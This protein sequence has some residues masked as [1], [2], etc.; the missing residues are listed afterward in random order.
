MKLDKENIK[1][2]AID[3]TRMGAK[4]AVQAVWWY[5][6]MTVIGFFAGGIGAYM[7]A[8]H[9]GYGG[10]LGFIAALLGFSLG[11]IAGFFTGQMIVLGI[12]QDMMLDA[13]IKTG[14]I[15]Y[16]RARQLLQERRDK[17]NAASAKKPEN[18]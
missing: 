16:K 14:K 2:K 11:T 9:F 7:A 8:A 12:I 1:L 18:L 6:A 10:W 3:Y 4:L 15:G 17:I 13:G 5:V